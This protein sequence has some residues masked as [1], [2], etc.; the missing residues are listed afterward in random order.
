[1]ERLAL[2]WTP[3]LIRVSS[4]GRVELSGRALAAAPPPSRPSRR[5]LLRDGEGMYVLERSKARMDFCGRLSRPLSRD[6]CAPAARASNPPLGLR[7]LVAHVEVGGV[8]G[9]AGGRGR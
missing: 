9:R 3:G 5:W 2:S 6:G 1:M 4:G 8:R 7:G